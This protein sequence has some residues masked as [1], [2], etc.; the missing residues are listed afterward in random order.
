[1]KLA[2]A[3]LVLL[4]MGVGTNSGSLENAAQ[5][6]E[7]TYSVFTSLLETEFSP[8]ARTDYFNTVSGEMSLRLTNMFIDKDSLKVRRSIDGTPL[9]LPTDGELV[10]ASEYM[11]DPVKGIVTM[12]YAQYPAACSLSVSYESGLPVSDQDETAL[13]TPQWLRDAA[14]AAAVHALNI[15]PSSPANRKASTV[16]A[17]SLEL[18]GLASTLLRQYYRPRLTV[19]L[20]VLSTLNE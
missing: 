3:D 8:Q 9:L 4:S 12:R 7:L 10:A 20:P 14:V 5:A 15:V 16:A 2:T 11:L 19:Y 13:D 17:V 1:M 18:R 6:L